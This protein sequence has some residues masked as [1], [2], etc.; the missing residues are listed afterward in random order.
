MDVKKI[1]RDIKINVRRHPNWISG[2]VSIN[3]VVHIF[4]MNH[5]HILE[6]FFSN[7]GE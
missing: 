7:K 4:F 6:T 3:I 1:P 5:I 2:G